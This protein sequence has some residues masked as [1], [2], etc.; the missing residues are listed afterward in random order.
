LSSLPAYDQLQGAGYSKSE[1]ENDMAALQLE[2]LVADLELE[3]DT[4]TLEL[5]ADTAGL[6]LEIDMPQETS[7]K[8][9]YL[10]D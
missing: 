6:E 9:R 4:T 10:V 2:T 7:K 8:E 1:V 5:E 3:M